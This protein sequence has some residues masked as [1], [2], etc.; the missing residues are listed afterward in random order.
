[1]KN[2]GLLWQLFAIIPILGLILVYVFIFVAVRKF[3]A[4]TIYSIDPKLVFK[5]CFYAISYYTHISGIVVLFITLILFFITSL[6]KRKLPTSKNVII[7]Y[8]ALIITYFLVHKIDIGNYLSW[9]FD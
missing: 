1:M 3:G 4:R 8:F 6:F 7:L 2:R 5:S 9:F